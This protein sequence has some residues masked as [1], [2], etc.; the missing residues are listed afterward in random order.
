MVVVKGV[1]NGKNY[2]SSVRTKAE[3]SAL[4]LKIKNTYNK[5]YLW[6]EDLKGKIMMTYEKFADRYKI[7]SPKRRSFWAVVGVVLGM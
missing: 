7:T 3:A 2:W 6:L 4:I 5:A 1:V